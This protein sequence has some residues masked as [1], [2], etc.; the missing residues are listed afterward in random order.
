MCHTSP[1][2]EHKLNLKQQQKIN[3]SKRYIVDSSRHGIVVSVSVAVSILYPYLDLYYSA[4]MHFDY[5]AHIHSHPQ[6]SIFQCQSF[7]TIRSGSTIL[8]FAPTIHRIWPVLLSLFLSTVN[9]L[10]NAACVFCCQIKL[11]N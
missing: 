5:N 3:S 1:L 11:E 6:G 9:Q 8:A 4:H 7:W 2:D 10:Q